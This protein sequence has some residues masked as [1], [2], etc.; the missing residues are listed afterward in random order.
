LDIVSADKIQL[1]V[2][3]VTADEID[4]AYGCYNTHRLGL[5]MSDLVPAGV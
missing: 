2:Q 3:L 5:F 4:L 1:V